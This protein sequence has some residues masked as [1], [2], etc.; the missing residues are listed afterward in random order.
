MV[1]VGNLDQLNERETRANTNI[2]KKSASRCGSIFKIPCGFVSSLLF[3]SSNS[4]FKAKSVEDLNKIPL[5]PNLMTKNI[6]TKYYKHYDALL[7]KKKKKTNSNELSKMIPTTTSLDESVLNPIQNLENGNIH[8][9]MVTRGASTIE[10]SN[11]LVDNFEGKLIFEALYATIRKKMVISTIL[12]VLSQAVMV[13]I[14][15]TM[16]QV[17]QILN[18]KNGKVLHAVPWIILTTLIQFIA[19]FLKQHSLKLLTGAKGESGQILKFIIF[20][21]ISLANFAFLKE[22]DVSFVNKIV[23]YELTHIVEYIDELPKFVSSPITLILLIFLI[24]RKITLAQT[25]ICVPFLLAFFSLTVFKLLRHKKLTEYY[26]WQSKKSAILTEILPGMKIVKSDNLV[27]HFKNKLDKIRKKEIRSLAGINF[28]SMFITLLTKETSIFILVIMIGIEVIIKNQK[29]ETQSIFSLITA[30]DLLE[31]PLE[32]LTHTID[33]MHSYISSKQTIISFIDQVPNK[34]INMKERDQN[35]DQISNQNPTCNTNHKKGSI[36][37][38]DC[39]FYFIN[40]DLMKKVIDQLIDSKNAAFKISKMIQSNKTKLANRGAESV[41]RAIQA[42]LRFSGKFRKGSLKEQ[43]AFD[44]ENYSLAQRMRNPYQM[45]LRTLDIRVQPGKKV[46]LTGKAGSGI[47]DFMLALIG[48]GKP[49]HPRRF[50]VEG[51]ISYLNVLMNNF[52]MGTIKENILCFNPLHPIRYN[53]VIDAVDLK[54]TKKGFDIDEIFLLEN[55][56]NISLNLKR[57]ILIARWA[58]LD[59]DIYLIDDLFD[60]LDK[61]LFERIYQHLIKNILSQKTVIYMS[62]DEEQIKLADVA[63]VF[64]EGRIVYKGKFL[65]GLASESEDESSSQSSSN[66]S[67]N[68]DCSSEPTQIQSVQNAEKWGDDLDISD[69]DTVK[70]RRNL[71]LKS[72]TMNGQSAKDRWKWLRNVILG[73]LFFKKIKIEKDKQIK[74]RNLRTNS[75]FLLRD[76]NQLMTSQEVKLNTK[77][78]TKN[79]RN[80]FYLNWKTSLLFI[81]ASLFIAFFPLSYDLIVAEIAKHQ[82]ESRQQFYI[83]LYIG[84]SLLGCLYLFLLVFLVLFGMTKNSKKIYQLSIKGLMKKETVWFESQPTEFIKYRMIEDVATLDL[85]YP[86]LIFDLLSSISIMIIGFGFLIR[87]YYGIAPILVA[88][89]ICWIFCIYHNYTRLILKLSHLKSTHNAELT[90]L[91]SELIN[92]CVPIR[93]SGNIIKFEKKFMKENDLLRKYSTLIANTAGRWLG[94]RLVLINTMVV[95]SVFIVPMVMTYFNEFFELSLLFMAMGISWGIKIQ[96]ALTSSLLKISTIYVNMSSISRLLDIIDKPSDKKDV[97]DT[98]EEKEEGKTKINVKNDMNS[99]DLSLNESLESMNR[100]VHQ[101]TFLNDLSSEGPRRFAIFLKNVNFMGFNNNYT[102]DF[103]NLNLIHGERIG[104]INITHSSTISDLF[105]VVLGLKSRKID[106]PSFGDRKE[107][108]VYINGESIEH[109]KGNYAKK[110]NDI[111]L[112]EQEPR[113]FAGTVLENIDP[114]SQ[115]ERKKVIYTLQKLKFKTIVESSLQSE[116][117]KLSGMKHLT[118]NSIRKKRGA[119]TTQ[120]DILRELYKKGGSKALQ[121]Q[122]LSSCLQNQKISNLRLSSPVFVRGRIQKQQEDIKRNLDSDDEDKLYENELE[123]SK[124]W[125]LSDNKIKTFKNPKNG[126]QDLGIRGQRK[127]V[128]RQREQLFM[129]SSRRNNEMSHGFDLSNNLNSERNTSNFDLSTDNGGI[130]NLDQSPQQNSLKRR[131]KLYFLIILDDQKNKE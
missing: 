95:F 9:H 71:R 54:S 70:Q 19:G 97:S 28:Y 78:I 1:R 85:K 122:R 76:D 118:K 109:R 13:A 20:K 119:R 15:L 103:L 50:R 93:G 79:F 112:L 121:K 6:M 128:R 86:H 87:I 72:K 99:N 26:V 96:K 35:S 2:K 100:S 88:L 104:L 113:I 64:S 77:K 63:V 8:Q 16:T 61:D 90:N 91:Y 36:I 32:F 33:E 68:S 30:L 124:D 94:I 120:F 18:D 82:S 105:S 116:D 58:Y 62:C 56:K 44:F 111:M 12:E 131:V 49:S 43:E 67:S 84:M 42:R 34:K 38:R 129:M 52:F 25:V 108:S 3:T 101:E 126:F 65:G 74:K 37:I 66:N 40:H 125:H 102:I 106:R 98:N 10:G 69:K 39:D 23:Q 11:L 29:L 55:A 81:F 17:F 127:T 45:L 46:C 60:D 92:S 117:G 48:E 73:G 75:V 89:L 51:Q 59:V 107:H 41:R 80:Y 53:L 130:N 5:N 24:S 7:K 115:Y 47:S 4:L 123:N 83:Y 22:A 31:G 110:D 57:K 114:Y 27:L 14:P 21:K